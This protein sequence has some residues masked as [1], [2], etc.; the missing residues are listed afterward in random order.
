MPL[1]KITTDNIDFSSNLVFSNVASMNVTTL[2]AGDALITGNLTVTGTTVTVN[3]NTIDVKDLNI[4]VAKGAGSSALSNGAGLTVDFPNAQ[5]FYA[6][7]DD[8]WN[9]NKVFKASANLDVSGNISISGT[10]RRITGDFSNATFANRVAFQ[11]STTNGA[12]QIAIVPNGT[13]TTATV[14]LFNTSDPNNSGRLNLAVIANEARISSDTTGSGAYLPMTFY[15]GGSERVRITSAGD[16]GIGTGTPGAKLAVAADT[17]VSTYAQVWDISSNSVFQLTNILGGDSTNG[18]YF[19]P[20]QNVPL[21]FITN[22]T[23]RVRIDA[24]GNM[25][26]NITPSPWGTGYK[27]YTNQLYGEYYSTNGGVVG[28]AVNAYYNGTNW[29]YKNTT[30]ASR[31]DQLIGSGHIWYNAP[32]GNVG[33]AVTFSEHMRLDGNGNLGIG[34]ASPGG[35]LDVNGVGI[36]R[37]VGGEGGEVQLLDKTNSTPATI[38]DVDGGETLRII[39]NKNTPTILYTS[40]AE[41]MRISGGGA[42][43]IGTSSQFLS[44]KLSVLGVVHSDTQYWSGGTTYNWRAGAEG[45]G[46]NAYI[47]YNSNGTGT[48][49][50]WGG[51]SWIANSDERLKDIIEPISNPLEKITSIRAVIGKYKKDPEGTRRSFL[52]AQDVQKVLPEAINDTPDGYLGIAYTETIPLLVAAIKELK[53]LN[54]QLTD[55]VAQL[56]ARNG[57]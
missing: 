18:A 3:T 45:T 33:T 13:G 17:A 5:M 29:I 36:F 14:Q 24:A 48:F 34:V 31:Y 9:V 56:E 12:T 39:N 28:L 40:G 16:V 57:I 11:T 41:R 26:L 6:S 53:V 7:S 55:R 47:C 54:D 19:G 4:T 2:N 43:L 10:G 23:E 21:R 42:V 44:A 30:N 49:I 38:I 51:T 25:G 1:T 46:Q 20:F 32:A 8:S 35:K 50:V 37:A 22:N 15:I 27:S 52:I